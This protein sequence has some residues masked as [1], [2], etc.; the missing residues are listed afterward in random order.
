M[1]IIPEGPGSNYFADC[2]TYEKKM[3]PLMGKFH[4]KFINDRYDVERITDVVQQ[5]RGSDV[6]YI[7]KATGKW[8]DADE[9]FRSRIEND[10]LLEVYSNIAKLMPGWGTNTNPRYLQ[11][12]RSCAATQ[13]A[14]MHFIRMDAINKIVKS[15]QEQIDPLI[16]EIIAD[17]R[18][19]QYRNLWGRE[20]SIVAKPSNGG[21]YRGLAVAIPFNL[22]KDIFK[23]PFNSYLW[24][25]KQ[26]AW[27][28]N[29][30]LN[31]I[32]NFK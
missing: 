6:R 30:V 20:I 25:Y 1:I 23:V 12:V 26:Q 32:Y 24:S 3:W 17:E 21:T 31:N 4:E 8:F 13:E 7:D 22:L 15:A 9:K 18:V 11:Y 19:Y 5:K 29:K 2:S 28:M 16:P 10:F 14:H 27:F